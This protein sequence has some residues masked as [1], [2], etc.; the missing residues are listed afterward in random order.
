[1]EKSAWFQGVKEGFQEGNLEMQVETYTGLN[2]FDMP[3]KTHL[4]FILKKMQSHLEGGM[5]EGS[6][7]GKGSQKAE[8]ELFRPRV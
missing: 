3:F 5:E 2:D 1:M 7:G 6:P 8:C 4:G